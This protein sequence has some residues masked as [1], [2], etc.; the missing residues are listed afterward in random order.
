MSLKAF[1]TSKTFFKQVL[2][3][4]GLTL[5]LMFVVLWLVR[6]YTNHGESFELPDLTGMSVHDAEQV[7]K[8]KNLE[9]EVADSLYLDGA[10]PGS[11]I[12]QV[13][14]AGHSVKEGRTIFLSICAV[15]PEQVVMPHLTDISL[16]QA[17]SMMQAVGLN[18]GRV[19]YQLS[20]FPNLVLEQ[21]MNSQP[22]PA[23]TRVNK[24]SNIDLLIGKSGDGEKTVVPNLLG[25]TLGQAK[26]E[27]A[28]LFLNLGAVIYDES[29]QTRED[30]L[31]AQ[32][33]QQRPSAD[34]YDEI[35]LGA[36]ID[37]WLSVNPDRQLL[38]PKTSLETDSLEGF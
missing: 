9:F 14:A 26:G 3:A 7:L 1:L 22:V 28:S 16:R 23:G 15:A 27:I 24:G 18:V 20:E 21:R 10:V 8:S 30:T 36:S 37:L 29:V 35:D 4:L 25:G 19:E 17:V 11:V 13:P 38:S 31:A 6:I 32:V 12:G 33:W 5:L 2:I 34:S